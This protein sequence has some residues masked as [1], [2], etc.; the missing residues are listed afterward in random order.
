MRLL[1]LGIT[2]ILISSCGHHKIRF[3]RMP[4]VVRVSN[5]SDQAQTDPSSDFRALSQIEEGTIVISS[6]D[7]QFFETDPTEAEVVSS[8]TIQDS[9]ELTD[10]E[11]QIIEWQAI[12]AEHTAKRATLNS[13][14]FLPAIAL[15]IGAVFLTGSMIPFFVGALIGLVFLILGIIYYKRASGSRYITQ[16]GER[17]LNYALIILIANALIIAALTV[18]AF[19]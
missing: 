3:I 9:T 7:S 17:F 8:M 2:L 11:Q 10:T 15:G 16:K 18:L 19:I 1:L 6:N 5:D 12:K 13:A 4:E 14:L